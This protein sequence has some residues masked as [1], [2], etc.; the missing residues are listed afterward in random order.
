MRVVVL[1]GP[2]GA[3]KGTQAQRLAGRLGLDHVA[4]GDLFRAAVREGTP[5]GAEVQG[6]MARGELVPD[7]LTVRVLK[8]RLDTVDAAGGVL[9]DGFPRTAAQAAALDEALAERGSRVDVAPLIEVPGD[10]LVERLGG[11][12][13]C[14]AAGHVYHETANPPRVSGVCDLDGSELYQRLDDQPATIRAR[15]E[16]QLGALAEVVEHY[17]RGGVLAPVDG[18]QSIDA[19]TTALLAVLGPIGS[20]RA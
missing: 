10:E 19:V 3:G 16:Q 14:R 9:L 18:S 12:W 6:Y 17:R 1:L 8:A 13:T 2:P 4:T 11:R 7:D 15:L 5:L 20:R